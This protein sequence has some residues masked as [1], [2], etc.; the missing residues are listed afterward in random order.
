MLLVHGAFTETTTWSGVVGDLRPRG[1]DAVAVPTP[2]TGLRADA[3]YVAS[4]ASGVD[5]PVLLAGEGY[6]GAVISAAAL[7]APNV[8]GLVF[9]AAFVPDEGE[10]CVELAR[11][12]GGHPGHRGPAPRRGARR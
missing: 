12:V 6:G 2:L 10:S 11:A 8:V 9:V 1:I 7:A 5:G 4:R 3:A